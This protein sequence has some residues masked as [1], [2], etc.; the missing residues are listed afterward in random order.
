VGS[1][2]GEE[3]HLAS[4]LRD[5]GSGT[6]RDD[7]GRVGALSMERAEEGAADRVSDDAGFTFDPTPQTRCCCCCCCWMRGA[8]SL[9]GGFVGSRRPVRGLNNM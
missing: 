9:G 1:N 3:D 2:D 6:E 4:S 5:F 7:E 8:V